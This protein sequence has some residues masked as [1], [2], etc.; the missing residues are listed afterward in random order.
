MLAPLKKQNKKRNP[1][2]TSNSFIRWLSSFLCLHDLLVLPASEQNVL[3]RKQLLTFF[4]PNDLVQAVGAGHICEGQS[5]ESS[6]YLA[7]HCLPSLWVEKNEAACDATPSASRHSVLGTQQVTHQGLFFTKPLWP[8]H[9]ALRLMFENNC[10][11]LFH[12]FPPRQ[13]HKHWG[14]VKWKGLRV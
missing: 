13:F 9:F 14:F 6:S 2:I 11:L 5:T 10:A 4:L 1:K 3:P 7:P 12:F 8:Q